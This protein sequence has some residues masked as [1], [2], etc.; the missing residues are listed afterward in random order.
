M[1]DLMDRLENQ[2]RRA[3]KL[4]DQQTLGDLL[5][6]LDELVPLNGKNDRYMAFC[7]EIEQT[8]PLM[9]PMVHMNGTSRGELQRQLHDAHAAITKA[10]NALKGA[11][12]NARDYYPKGD[13]AY[14]TARDQ[15]IDRLTRLET[16]QTEL[17]WI[18]EQIDA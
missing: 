7:T 18:F 2:A 10:L 11:A 6:Q 4:G 8:V 1:T 16:V 12:P 13:D 9:L 17:L 3:A 14:K 15:H 5:K